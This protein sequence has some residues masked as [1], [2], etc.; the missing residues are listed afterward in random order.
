MSNADL[1]TNEDL[2]MDLMTFSRFGPMGHVFVIEAIRGY[3]AQILAEP[4]RKANRHDTVDPELWR[5]IA[6]DVKDRCDSFY[7]QLNAGG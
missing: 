6:A 3:A 5:S 2:V 7:A 4:V 1:E